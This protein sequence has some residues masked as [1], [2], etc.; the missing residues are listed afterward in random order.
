MTTRN[1]RL[2]LA[3]FVLVALV[4]VSASG[5]RN[6]QSFAGQ[7]IAFDHKIHAGDYQ[8]SCQ[9]CH[10][11]ADRSPV[12]GVPSVKTCMGCHELIATDK[13][14]IE[15]LTR[16]WQDEQPIEWIKVYDVPDFV[17]FPHKS[18]VRA[19]V[20]CQECHGAVETMETIRKVGDL[21][22]GWCLECHQE[23]KA[24]IDCLICHH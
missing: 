23:R 17:R 11:Y 13:P 12:A 7:P 9:Y 1:S 5:R 14:E 22:M 16:F 24:E 4:F 21:S 20:E 6:A 3:L 18:H 15:N 10:L 2:G 8:I 19:G